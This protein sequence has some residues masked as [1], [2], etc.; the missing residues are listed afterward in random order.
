MSQIDGDLANQ[1]FKTVWSP[2][3]RATPSVRASQFTG[4]VVMNQWRSDP[5]LVGKFHPEF[6]DDLQVLVHDGGPRL[7][8]HRPELVWVRIVA[9]NGSTFTGRVLN[10]P[11]Q[12]DSVQE[13]SVI[14][15]LVPDGVPDPLMV[16]EKYLRERPDWIVHPCTDCGLTELFDAPSDL[17]KVVFANT[18][19]GSIIQM[20]TAICG[21]CGGAQ[22]VEYKDCDNGDQDLRG[23]STKRWWEFWK[24][25][26]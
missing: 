5:R 14:T 9:C 17:I 25:G 23:K 19:E 3:K 13:G 20:F 6:P 10:Q 26:R 4:I 15:F 21:A 18:P 7:T 24:Y 11:Q 8:D 1:L 22:A 12:L 16:T 2:N